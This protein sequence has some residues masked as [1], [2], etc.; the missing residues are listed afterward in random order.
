MQRLT[1]THAAL[2]LIGC[3]DPGAT[4]DP[5]IGQL[6][7]DPRYAAP[8]LAGVAALRS[9]GT[10]HDR[11][12]S[13]V[14]AC[15]LDHGSALCTV[16]D[17]EGSY[18]LGPLTPNSRWK[19]RYAGRGLVPLVAEYQIPEHSLVG[20]V[21]LFSTATI[22][23]AANTLRVQHDRLR[24]GVVISARGISYDG[25]FALDGVRAS[26]LGNARFVYAGAANQLDRNLEATTSSG[27]GI[28]FGVTPGPLRVEVSHVDPTVTC[29]LLRQDLGATENSFLVETQPGEI[30]LVAVFCHR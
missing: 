20:D 13:G 7:A 17:Q 10:A 18:T 29:G 15:V 28:A 19:V 16:S 22:E 8:R 1:M 11:P 30:T 23:T 9:P 14:E 4:A 27:W 3:S 24:S 2:L 6:A 26:A 5:E 12:A 21:F 25:L